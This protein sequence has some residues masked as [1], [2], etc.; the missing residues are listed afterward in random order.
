MEWP[1]TLFGGDKRGDWYWSREVG[2][3]G[4]GAGSGSGPVGG[5]RGAFAHGSFRRWSRRAFKR[6]NLGAKRRQA[7]GQRLRRSLLRVQK[8]KRR[9]QLIR[10]EFFRGL[11]ILHGSNE[12]VIC[13]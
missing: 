1:S 12:I 11:Q 2:D 5:L 6:I 4:A 9:F 13:R 3:P 8:N 10:C 7:V